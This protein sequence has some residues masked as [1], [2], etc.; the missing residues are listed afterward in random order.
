[1]P[2]FSG[3]RGGLLALAGPTGGYLI[4]FILASYLIGYLCDRFDWARRL[5]GL[6]G[7]MVV[8]DFL[9]I[10]GTGMLWLSHLNR[11]LSFQTLLSIGLLPFVVGDLT[12]IMA[13]AVVSG[14]LTPKR[15]Y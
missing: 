11:S 1:M 15:S 13:A 9:I 7:L 10:N 8:A 6:V 2:W 4:G 14:A 12:K 5:P 3:A